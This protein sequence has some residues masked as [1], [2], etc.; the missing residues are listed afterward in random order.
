MDQLI[1]KLSDLKKNKLLPVT[2][3]GKEIV[4]FLHK[5]NTV[6]ALED[7]CSHADFNLSEGDFDGEEVTCPAHGARFDCRTGKNL[8][9]PAVCPVK[10]YKVRVVDGAVYIEV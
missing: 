9:L 10:A 3:S 2:V 1:A 6:S 8:C 7:K 5:D 4:L